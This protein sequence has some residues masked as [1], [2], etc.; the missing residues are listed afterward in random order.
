MSAQRL[1]S[2]RGRS[3]LPPFP[4]RSPQVAAPGRA[5]PREPAGRRRSGGRRQPGGEGALCA[6]EEEEED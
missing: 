3:L 6:A 1:R 5:G 4:T 2:L